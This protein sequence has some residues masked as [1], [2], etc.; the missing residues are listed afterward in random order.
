MYT[1][2]SM[3]D[4]NVPFRVRYWNWQDVLCM[5][6]G[7]AVHGSVKEKLNLHMQTSKVKCVDQVV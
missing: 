6:A 2:G 5:C 3:N 7:H 4:F 1:A